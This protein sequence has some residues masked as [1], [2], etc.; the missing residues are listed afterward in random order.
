V[1]E[2]HVTG[3]GVRRCYGHRA[4][5]QSGADAISVDPASNITI[6]SCWDGGGVG[7]V[8]PGK[9]YSLYCLIVHISGTFGRRDPLR[10]L[11]GVSPKT[12]G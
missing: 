4:T 1:L 7:Q 6:V 9:S 8:F 12:V 11:C 5:L 2:D 10:R 3:G